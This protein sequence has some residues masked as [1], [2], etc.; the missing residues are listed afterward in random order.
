MSLVIYLIKLEKADAASPATT[1]KNKRVSHPTPQLEEQACL[2]IHCWVNPEMNEKPGQT[3]I[4]LQNWA[5]KPTSKV[6][7]TL[8]GIKKFQETPTRKK[9]GMGRR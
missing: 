5:Q 9:R 4:L 2:S 1:Q 8:A 6:M 7:S 3:I